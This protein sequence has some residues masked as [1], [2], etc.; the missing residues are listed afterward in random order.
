LTTLRRHLVWIQRMTSRS[1]L[2]SMTMSTSVR[3]DCFKTPNTLHLNASLV[4][5]FVPRAYPPAHQPSSLLKHGQIAPNLRSPHRRR[6]ASFRRS[7]YPP[8]LHHVPSRHAPIPIKPCSLRLPQVAVPS[9]RL[10]PAVC[11]VRNPIRASS[12]S[13]H[14][15]RTNV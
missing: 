1:D 4:Q 9:S 6:H 5:E 11:E 10:N 7:D 2:L 14:P 15:F 3:V 12:L 8:H 13:P